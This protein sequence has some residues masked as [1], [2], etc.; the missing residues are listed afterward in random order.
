MSI[1]EIIKEKVKAV[2]AKAAEFA[3]KMLDRFI[4]TKTGA[5]VV[6]YIVN[7][8]PGKV[9]HRWD[10][11]KRVFSD[12]A[13]F[14]GTSIGTMA[15]VFMYRNTIHRRGWDRSLVGGAT[16]IAARIAWLGLSHKLGTIARDQVEGWFDE[17]KLAGSAE[18]KVA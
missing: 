1:I 18:R 8:D 7:I 13:Y 17:V 11:A 4:E 15:E 9:G 3:K 10:M 14:G 16:K 5:A 12:V 2:L 6:T